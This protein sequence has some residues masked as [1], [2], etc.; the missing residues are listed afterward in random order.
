[1]SELTFKFT[2]ENFNELYAFCRGYCSIELTTPHYD[3]GKYYLHEIGTGKKMKIEVDDVIVYDTENRKYGI[4]VD[5][6]RLDRTI[7]C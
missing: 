6:I 5:G 1:M 7:S 3:Q 4:V 2:G